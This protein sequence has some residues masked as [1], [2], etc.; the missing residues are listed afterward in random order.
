MKYVGVFLVIAG[1]AAAIYLGGYLMLIGGIVQIVEAVKMDDIPA[2]SVA[3][4]VAR[5]LL[6]GFTAGICVLITFVPGAA[7]LGMK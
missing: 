4:G 5:V 6:A 2:A 1:M 7:L 3:W